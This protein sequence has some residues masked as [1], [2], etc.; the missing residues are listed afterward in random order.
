MSSKKKKKIQNVLSYLKDSFGFSKWSNF[1]AF[2]AIA[3]FTV[4]YV[5]LLISQQV[6]P[7]NWVYSEGYDENWMKPEFNPSGWTPIDLPF[8]EFEK[9]G[10]LS[11]YRGQVDISGV[12]KPDI[13]IEARR[14]IMEIYINGVKVENYTITSPMIIS[15]YGESATLPSSLFKPGKNILAVS[16][17]GDDKYRIIGIYTKKI[18]I[19][20]SWT[21]LLF[22][23]TPAIIFFVLSRKNLESTKIALMVFIISTLVFLTPIFKDFNYWGGRDWGLTEGFDIVPRETLLL[24]HQIPLWN[25]YVS[26]GTPLLADA[27]SLCLSPLFPIIL[28]F[29]VMS[30]VKIQLIVWYVLGLFGMYLI[31]KELKMKTYAIYLMAFVFMYSSFYSLHETEGH[32]QT[33]SMPLLPWVFL[34]YLRALE[35]KKYTIL[36]GLTMAFMLFDGGIYTLVSTAMILTLYSIFYSVKNVFE[37][38][39]RKNILNIFTTLF[40]VTILFFSIGAIKAI[41][42]IELSLRYPRLTEIDNT[43]FDGYSLN[44]LYY[45]FLGQIQRKYVP[46]AVVGF[47]NGWHEFGAYLGPV[48]LLLAVGG[49]VFYVKREWP[50]ALILVAGLALAFGTS[51]SEMLIWS[52]LHHFP[53]FSS[54]RTPSRFILIALFPL[55]LFTGYM[56][57]KIESKKIVIGLILALVVFY[58][59]LVVDSPTL[60]EAFTLTPRMVNNAGSFGQIVDNPQKL[61]V[62]GELHKRFLENKGVLNYGSMAFLSKIKPS[63]KSILDEDYRGEVYLISGVGSAVLKYFS[64]NRLL[65]EISTQKDDTLII[66]QE[67]DS[68]WKTPGREV[69]NKTGLIAVAVNP[70][71]SEILLY[72]S[73]TSFKVGLIVTLFTLL[74]VINYYRLQEKK[75]TFTNYLKSLKQKKILLLTV[76]IIGFSTYGVDIIQSATL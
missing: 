66:N 60:E 36:C 15:Q 73:P 32:I 23:L 7:S 8:L 38:R 54:L 35:D 16:V 71:D 63:A 1:I 39:H 46:D 56:A 19:A 18:G 20:D 58:N 45:A 49:I 14:K 53:V 68:G 37:K 22:Y 27:Q 69:Y 43:L 21:L 24:Y 42:L 65:V 3:G 59:L 31:G 12:I 33:R 74:L 50:L 17:V 11:Y 4:L 6:V 47:R 52:L 2:A 76:L 10:R 5:L 40:A 55:Y 9:E 28:V 34:F 67:Y 70:E 30:G 26:G 44:Y 62:Y 29:N 25:P 48:A 51:Q 72:Y 75:R 64:P 13:T 41:P 57:S 61:Y